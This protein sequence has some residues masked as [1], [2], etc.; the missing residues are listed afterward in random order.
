M[1]ANS[2]QC[3]VCMKYRDLLPFPTSRAPLPEMKGRVYSSYVRSS[4]IYGSETRPSL[5]D[6]GLNFESRDADD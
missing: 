3:T 4:M 2:V 5:V 1:H 6:V